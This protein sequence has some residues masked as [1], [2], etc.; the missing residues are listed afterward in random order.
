MPP[1]QFADPHRQVTRRK[2]V[3]VMLSCRIVSRDQLVAQRGTLRARGKRQGKH[4][5]REVLAVL[6]VSL[7][8]IRSCCPFFFAGQDGEQAGESRRN[9]GGQ[10]GR[11]GKQT[12]VKA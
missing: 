1:F 3:A 11:L 5:D 7:L 10:A 2:S 9:P 8:L 4:S 12:I 6:S